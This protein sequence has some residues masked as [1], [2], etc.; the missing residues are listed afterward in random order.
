MVKT[1]TKP[2]KFQPD[3][4]P[5]WANAVLRL[6]YGSMARIA[7]TLHV[8]LAIVSYVL[9][10]DRTSKR[11]SKAILREATRLARNPKPLSLLSSLQLEGT[12]HDGAQPATAKEER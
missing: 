5:A 10:G 9:S 11:V 2:V 7:R 6:H 12:G 4:I 8:S 3:R 1:T